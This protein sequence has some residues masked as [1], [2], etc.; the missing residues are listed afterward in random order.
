[1]SLG[2]L[3][4]YLEIFKLLVIYRNSKKDIQDRSSSSKST[5]GIVVVEEVELGLG[6][7]QL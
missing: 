7:I 1:M 2:Y 6:L 3:F 4:G 5:F